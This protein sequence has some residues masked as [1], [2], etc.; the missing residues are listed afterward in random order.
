M[1]RMLKTTER[2]AVKVERSHNGRFKTSG[3]NKSARGF[4]TVD[5]QMPSPAWRSPA[6][7]VGALASSAARAIGETPDVDPS[8]AATK[9][10]GSIVA[11]LGRGFGKLLGKGDDDKKD[12]TWLKRIWQTLRGSSEDDSAFRKVELRRL[13]AL[14]KR[15]N[16]EGKNAA[17]GVGGMFGGLMSK[18]PS[19]GGIGGLASGAL[20]LGKGFMRR[21]PLL[22]ALFAGGSALASI[23]GGDDADKTPEENRKSRFTGGGSGIGA[24]IGGGLGALGGPVGIVIGGIIGDKVGELVGGWLSKFDWSKVGDQIIVTWNSGVAMFTSAWKSVT[25]TIKPIADVAK[26]ILDGVAGWLKGKGIALF[27]GTAALAN[28]ANDAVKGATGID[29]KAGAAKATEVVSSATAAGYDAAKSGVGAVIN[30]GKDRAAKMA[31]PILNTVGLGNLIASHEGDYGSYNRGM[32]GDAKGKKLDFSSMTIDDIMAQQAKP[33]GDSDRLFAVGKY[34]I[35]PSTMKGAVASMKLS[36]NENFTPELQER[37]FSEYL[38]DKKRPEI[39]GY[40][41]GKHDDVN[42][43]TLAASKEWASIEDPLTGKSYYDKVGNN[44]A[45]TSA[46]AISDELISARLTYQNGISNGMDGKKAM[47]YALSAASISIPSV[48]AIPAMPSISGVNPVPSIPDLAPTSSVTQINTNKPPVIQV[49][50]A[51]RDVGQ[52]LSDRRIAHIATAGL[53]GSGTFGYK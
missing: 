1:N 20:S 15:P 36:G 22:G 50:S 49:E 24:L 13:A 43:A 46:K 32:S 29:V 11:P 51:K 45:A 52:D 3:S 30:Y 27:D 37:I 4:V 38:A 14:D 48:S 41:S 8:I 47:A 5:E 18:L 7:K 34:Q 21:I 6:S 16:V 19:L 23:F 40:I 39:S 25:D 33:R 9:E 26:M 53:S 44:K 42:K 31:S 12:A 35:I 28:R 2:E 10:F 17:G